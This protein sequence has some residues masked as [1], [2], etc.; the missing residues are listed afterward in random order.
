MSRRN[1][2]ARRGEAITAEVMKNIQWLR[3]KLVAQVEFTEW[4]K[5]NHLR[6]SRFIALR[7]DKIASDVKNE[8]TFQP[9]KSTKSTKLVFCD[10]CGFLWLYLLGGGQPK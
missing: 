1:A 7:D 10:F 2:S 9:Q 3:P 6:H 8:M 4:T 5:G